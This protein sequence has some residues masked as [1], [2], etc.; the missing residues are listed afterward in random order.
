LE[1]PVSVELEARMNHCKQ[2]QM[3]SSQK[4][5]ELENKLKDAKSIQEKALKDA[6]NEMKEIKR[7]SEESLSLWKQ[8]EQVL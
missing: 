2:V 1:S 4:A 6:E 7:K 8:R 3:V 5:K